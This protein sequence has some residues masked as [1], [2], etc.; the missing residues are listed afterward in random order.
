MQ[1][2]IT[3]FLLLG[4]CLTLLGCS[5]HHGLQTRIMAGADTN[6]C[7]VVLLP[8]ENWTRKQEVA[9]LTERL[10]TSQL[11]Q[12]GEFNLV[13]AGDVGMFFLRQRL[14]PGSSLFK[15]HLTDMA[16]QL[17][18]DVVIQGRVVDAGS[19]RRSGDE[20]VPF[21]SLA[22]NVYDADTGALVLN[23]VHQRKGDDFRKLMHFGVETTLSGLTEKMSQEIIEDWFNKGITCR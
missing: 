16:S 1:K 5:N 8:F 4:L 11:L 18:V 3:Y 14:R 2:K 17:E 13:Q 12:T 15:R 20:K 9:L 21:L 6:I 23:T 19:V 7:S 10:F 22:F